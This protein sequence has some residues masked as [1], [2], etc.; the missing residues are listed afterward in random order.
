MMGKNF[1]NSLANGKSDISQILLRIVA[2]TASPNC[3]IV[4]LAD[5]LRII[6][7]YP[8]PRQSFLRV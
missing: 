1:L 6:E 4:G 7:R 8:Q 2:E 3:V 5:I